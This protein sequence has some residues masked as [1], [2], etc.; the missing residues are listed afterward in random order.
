MPESQGKGTKA[1]SNSFDLYTVGSVGYTVGSAEGM[2]TE[3]SSFCKG[4]LGVGLEQSCGREQ[5]SSH[6][7]VLA[8]VP[9]GANPDERSFPCFPASCCPRQALTQLC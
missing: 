4:M 3:A 8:R 6:T 7:C 1:L 2:S 5:R 9:G